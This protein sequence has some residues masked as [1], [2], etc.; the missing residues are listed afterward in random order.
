M[1]ALSGVGLAAQPGFQYGSFLLGRVDNGQIA[2]RSVTR[3]GATAYSG[4]A[5]D[6]WK[7][8]RKL[9]LRLR[10]ALRFRNLPARR[11]W[12]LHRVL[13]EYRESQCR[14]AARRDGQRW[15]RRRAMQLQPGEELPD[16]WDP[17]V[18]VAYQITPGTVL[19]GGAAIIYN[20]TDDN[21]IGFSSGSQY[22]YGTPSYA[23]PAYLMQD[24]LPYQIKFP[25]FDPGQYPLA[26]TLSAPPQLRTRTPGGRR[27]PSTASASSA[28]SSVTCWRT[29][30]TS[31]MSEPGG[32]PRISC[33][34]IPSSTAIWRSTDSMQ[35]KNHFMEKWDLR[36]LP[37]VKNPNQ[38]KRV[39]SI[40]EIVFLTIFGVGWWLT[41]FPS[42]QI[43]NYPGIRVTLTSM[44]WVFFWGFLS[45]QF[46]KPC[47]VE[48]E[49]CASL[50]DYAPCYVE[51]FD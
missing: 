16:G 46:G 7:V 43:L 28:K 12:L 44:W 24:G 36:K 42:L 6:T 11:P 18:G 51:A 31:A 37:P 10:T 2:V 27:R 9:T 17:R 23:D 29:S 5:Q 1:N 19:R 49:L 20:K 32:T 47:I 13:R 4:F 3:M 39:N 25:N 21:N 41:Y 45:Q 40:F 30:G 26:G 8:T 34:S 35:A 50:L 33:S 15:L 38:I 14:R 22:R 48:Y